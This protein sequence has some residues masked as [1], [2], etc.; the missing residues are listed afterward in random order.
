MLRRAS[1]A[2]IAR[3]TISIDPALLRG[4]K[5]VIAVAGGM[6]KT[7]AI[8]GALRGGYVNMLVTDITTA[9]AISA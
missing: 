2:A 8:I 9:Q 7:D 5:R 4:V 6:D 1:G 3:R